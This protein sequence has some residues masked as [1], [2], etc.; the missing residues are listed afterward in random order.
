MAADPGVSN[1]SVAA[2]WRAWG[3]VPAGGGG[4]RF[5]TEPPLV[6]A[7]CDLVGLLVTPRRRVLAVAAGDGPRRAGPHPDLVS[8]L[9]ALAVHQARPAPADPEP[10]PAAFLDAV[11]RVPGCRLVVTAA[12]TLPAGVPPEHVAAAARWPRIVHVAAA[13]VGG[14]GVA[15]L[16]AALDGHLAGAAGGAF[17]WARTRLSPHCGDN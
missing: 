2:I 1:G 4:V 12:G 6:E 11:A 3:I 13:L 10:D 14:P 8:R 16:V 15:E 9:A 7:V 17:T 5:A